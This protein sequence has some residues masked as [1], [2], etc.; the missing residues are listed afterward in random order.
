MTHTTESNRLHRLWTAVIDASAA[1]VAIRYAAPWSE[2]G[3]SRGADDKW[4]WNG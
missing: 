4:R 2:P 3:A 1:M